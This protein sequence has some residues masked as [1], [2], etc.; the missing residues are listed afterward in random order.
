MLYRTPPPVNSVDLI[1]SG[2]YNEY[3]SAG[4]VWAVGIFEAKE[5]R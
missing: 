4:A 1:S 2:T 5:R 3:L